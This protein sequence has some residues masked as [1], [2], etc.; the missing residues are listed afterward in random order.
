MVGSLQSR[1]SAA[2]ASD[3][4]ATADL[5]PTIA[6]FVFAWSAAGPENGPRNRWPHHRDE[7]PDIGR[8]RPAPDRLV[9]G[10][11]LL[12][13]YGSVDIAV[14]VVGPNLF[15]HSIPVQG[16]CN[17]RLDP[18]KPEGEPGLLNKPGDFGHLR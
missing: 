7:G 14:D 2:T 8:V 16:R 13:L 15:Q 10:R 9:G 4:A 12:R 11:S 1:I 5:S 3:I 17:R 6:A 18:G